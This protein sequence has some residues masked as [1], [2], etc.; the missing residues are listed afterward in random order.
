MGSL[1]GNAIRDQRR[2]RK[3]T[4]REAATLIAELD[5]TGTW[6]QSRLARLEEGNYRLATKDLEP[7][8]RFLETDPI[9][10]LNLDRAGSA[11]ALVQENDELKRRLAE[12]EG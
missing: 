7:L 1:L 3:M 10:V 9:T 6:S 11:V 8:S 4:Q 2:D 5:E 12:L